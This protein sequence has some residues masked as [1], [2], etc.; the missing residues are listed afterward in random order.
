MPR[1][2][3]VSNGNLLLNFDSDYQV[4]DIYFPYIGQENHTKGDPFKFGVWVDGVCAWMGPA[5]EKDL[6]Y[7]DNS[8]VTQ[9]RLLNT[10]AELELHC[11]DVVDIELNVYIKRIQVK[12]LTAANRQVRLFLSHDFSLSG[13]DVGDTAYFDP[14][15]FTVIHYKGDRYFL[16]DCVTDDTSGVRHYSCGGRDIPGREAS[17][18]DAED[19]ELNRTAIAWG[20][21]D[22]TIG[23]W[24]DVP[25]HGTATAYYW[26]A[27]GKEYQEVA[28]LTATVRKL[29]P[30]ALISRTSNYWKAWIQ[31][32][33]RELGNLPKA[34]TDL[35]NRS[36][37]ILRTQIDARGA[38]IAANDSDIIRFGKD[39]YSYMWGRDGAFVAAALSEAGYPEVCR[40]FFEFCARAIS[41]DGYLLQ[42]YSPDG[43]L[44]SN[45]HPWVVNG[46]SVLPIQEDS[47][48]LI[49]WA[50]WIHY[51]N[52]KDIE[53]IRPFYYGFIKKSADFL[54]QHRDP[55]TRLPLPSFDLWEERFGVHTFTVAA[56]LAGLKAA[57][58]FAKLFQ[59]VDLAINYSEVASQMR[60]ALVT[61][62]YHP[63]LQRFTRSGYRSEA[64]YVLD[65]VIDASLL[66]L[67]VL[68]ALP[69]ND[70]RMVKTLDAVRQQ[71][72][73]D[74]DIAGCARY[75]NDV[76]QKTADRPAGVAGNPW[77]ISTLWL[78]DCDVA[79]AETRQQL[80]AALPYLEWCSRNALPSGV[81]AEQVDPLDGSPLSVSP[82]TWSHSGF[83]WTVLQYA[84]KFR[85]LREPATDAH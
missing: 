9:V 25:P 7:E 39:T 65:E 62:L 22:S 63:P 54:V 27:A 12:N 19:G 59:D 56:V 24:L 72:W 16:I 48:A 17:W 15:T 14:R 5:W 71:L 10:A 43:S 49:L 32:E 20:S 69:A 8:L 85:A 64:G 61:H 81:L 74:T 77:F 21:A 68:D 23:I 52:C 57:A 6:R 3:P 11:A 34:V 83:V 1:D 80:G 36:L 35:F 70:P 26:I 18:R 53:F 28:S 50:L 29:T 67:I 58:N 51:E 38:I 44:A 37:L 66:G 47:T 30:Q 40:K 41:D 46:E 78:G 73:L 82:L 84:K 76:Y 33:S 31:I 4:R 42:H 79:Q 60:Q 45:W 2:I 13:N 75:Q 55:Q